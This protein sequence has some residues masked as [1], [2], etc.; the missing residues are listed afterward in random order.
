[1]PQDAVYGRR[2]NIEHENAN[3][4]TTATLKSLRLVLAQQAIILLLGAYCAE[5]FAPD[6]LSPSCDAAVC[7][8]AGMKHCVLFVSALSG[9]LAFDAKRPQL[10]PVTSSKR[11]I[12]SC[13]NTDNS[14]GLKVL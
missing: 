1:M 11:L 9:A 6:V 14:A 12:Q 5:S 13:M 3:V 2:L 7:D 8:V 10:F 4:E